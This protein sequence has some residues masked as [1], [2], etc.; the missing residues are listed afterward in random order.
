MP[1]KIA[2]KLLG[3]TGIIKRKV[4]PSLSKLRQPLKWGEAVTRSVCLGCGTI[5]E[6][7]RFL[8][9]EYA[10]SAGITLPPSL[11][12]KYLESA[13]CSLCNVDERV[14]GIK[15]KTLLDS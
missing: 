13:A 9:E 8:A 3:K 14:K 11:E 5:L 12:G 7:N 15:L 6:I 10:A 1:D 4:I 2:E